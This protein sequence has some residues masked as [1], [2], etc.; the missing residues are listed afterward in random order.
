MNNNNGF[1]DSIKKDATKGKGNA[2]FIA[3]SDCPLTFL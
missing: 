1:P 3:V 2:Y